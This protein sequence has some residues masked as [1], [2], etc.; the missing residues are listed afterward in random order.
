MIR[1]SLLPYSL[2]AC[3]IFPMTARAV[4]K[5]DNTTNLNQG[6]SWSGGTAPGVFDV[7]QWTSAFSATSAA[8]PLLLGGNVTWGGITITNPGGDVLI[9]TGNTLTLGF[10]SPS[11]HSINM[12]S[13]TQNLTIQSG[14]TLLSGSS[15][16]WNIASGRTLTLSD[17]T[18]TRGTGATLN[19]QGTGTITTTNISNVQ[20]IIGPWVTM[21]T[22]ASIRYATVDG[23]NHIIAYTA[24]TA[25]AT[26][27][28]IT[29]ATG[30]V[31]YDLAAGGALGAGASFNTVRYIGAAA[32]VTGD[33]SAKGILNAGT[34]ALS[35]SGNVVIGGSRDLT[36]HAAT[37]DITLTGNIANN[38]GGASTLTKTGANTVYL[39][40]SNSYTGMTVINNGVLDVGNL[41]NG[42]LG[43]GG[44]L[45]NGNGTLQGYGTFTRSFSSNVT[46]GT[47]QVA[48]QNGGFAARGGEL[49]LNFGGNATPSSI[50]L[51]GSGYI[52]GNDFRFG[53][54]TADNKV[55]VLNPIVIN[56]AGRRNITVI[57][58]VGGDSAELRGVLSNGGV[59]LSPSGIT[60]SGTGLLILSAANTY[61][62]VTQIAAGTL[63]IDSIADG[64]V[65]SNLGASS[66][67]ASNLVFDGGTLRYTGATA[68][69]DRS[70]TI[71]AA[72][73]AT[74]EV[75]T[76]ATNLTITGSTTAT[77]GGLT[78]SGAGTLTLTGAM[79]HTGQNNITGG[80][81]DIGPMTNL[82]SGGLTFTNSAIL[83][84]NGTLNRTFS[85]NATPTAGQLSGQTG[86]FAARGG[87]LTLNLGSSIGLNTALYIFG[88]NFIFG[89]P[90]AD[91]KVELTS[92]INLNSSNSDRVVTVNSG[93]GGDYAVLSGAISGATS[94]LRKEGMGLL[95]LTGANTYARIT[96]VNGG[97]LLANYT[98]TVTTASSTGVGPVTVA[99]A[100]TL[101][102]FGR[103]GTGS[104][105]VTVNGRLSPG[106]T[107]LTDTRDTLTISGSLT[108]GSAATTQLEV[109]SLSDHDKVVVTDTVTLDGIVNVDFTGFSSSNFSSNFTLDLFD[110][111]NLV[112]SGFTVGNGASGDLR[113]L[114][115]DYGA[116]V[117]TWDFSEFL[118]TGLNGGSISWNVVAVP[119]PTRVLFLVSGLGLVFLRRRRC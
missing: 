55:V 21:G 96:S 98:G 23:S 49:I 58:G 82:G 97:T 9:G 60:K 35:F 117:G 11:G 6:A 24:G 4:N 3:V 91:S 30:T 80:I 81:L 64:G 109:A 44:L 14:L 106:D 84:G 111:A 51:N 27:N 52:F 48:G 88:T 74:I 85:S 56:S 75:T 71:N 65:V 102:G 116:N 108:L 17:G 90:T 78:K 86:G 107:T 73:T 61:T 47:N 39:T 13:A 110:W 34:G 92:D 72:K 10:S 33:F 29:D 79:L 83:Q 54:A 104:T 99:A 32:S 63:S 57:S 22:G 19:I 25:A 103:V 77:T 112:S 94:G 114:N 40:G 119:E 95:T 20:G 28:L 38:S 43:S 87:D 70:F 67:A 89:S 8:T 42:S 16:S 93:V 101:G 12:S 50:A 53:S 1:I 36:L 26:A 41:S 115:L 5:A 105:L 113:F 37:G 66:N 76:A 15:Q 2:L 7:A 68:S 46:P 18:F 69:T 31:N 59:G 62:G 118:S 100:G 45:I